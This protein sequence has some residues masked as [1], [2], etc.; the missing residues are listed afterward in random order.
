MIIEAAFEP[1]NSARDFKKVLE[2]AEETSD[3][4]LLLR[5]KRRGRDM[6]FAIELDV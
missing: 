3:K 2:E 5:V 6:F 4:P 1:I